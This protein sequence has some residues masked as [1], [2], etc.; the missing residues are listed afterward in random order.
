MTDSRS[1]WRQP[2]IAI[3]LVRA[4]DVRLGLQQPR[5]R[6]RQ[7]GYNHPAPPERSR[8]WRCRAPPVALQPNR[9]TCGP[10]RSCSCPFGPPGT[11]HEELP[12]LSIRDRRRAMWS[13]S[14][15]SSGADELESSLTRSAQSIESDS[16]PTLVEGREGDGQWSRAL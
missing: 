16:L 15:L 7:C 1:G 2:C 5:S 3:C 13:A 12:P 14:S 4:I 6:A 8:C 10:T 11:P 9:G